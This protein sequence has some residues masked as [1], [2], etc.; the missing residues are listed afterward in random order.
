MLKTRT[1]AKTGSGQTFKHRENSQQKDVFWQRCARE[2]LDFPLH[3][4]D[5]SGGGSISIVSGWRRR[6]GGRLGGV[7][8]RARCAENTSSLLL[9]L[10]LQKSKCST[11]RL[12]LKH[13]RRSLHYCHPQG[14]QCTRRRTSSS[15]LS[16]TS[17]C[18]A[19]QPQQP[20]HP[21]PRRRQ[22]QRRRRRQR[23]GLRSRLVSV[24][25]RRT[26]RSRMSSSLLCPR[27]VS[28]RAFRARWARIRTARHSSSALNERPVP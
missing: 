12:E 24:G 13:K 15:T 10:L 23:H 7:C 3:A 28:L 20:L 17:P 22:R 11:Q 2:C 1:F 16:C 18:A 8:A 5:G 19:S 4:R 9:L 25:V 6:S 26:T 14:E 21:P 27:S